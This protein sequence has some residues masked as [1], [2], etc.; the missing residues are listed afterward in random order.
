[1]GIRIDMYCSVNAFN[2]S[3]AWYDPHMRFTHVRVLHAL[4]RDFLSG[5]VWA[6]EG[7]INPSLSASTLYSFG[8]GMSAGASI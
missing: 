8:F 5:L 7:V 4:H 1:M 3:N 6:G 2:A